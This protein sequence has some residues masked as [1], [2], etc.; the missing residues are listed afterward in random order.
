[1]VPPDTEAVTPP[2]LDVT[3]KLVAGLPEGAV[4]L[5]TAEKLPG[6]ALTDVAAPGGP[7]GPP[8]PEPPPPP[9]QPDSEI[10]AP[11]KTAKNPI[12]T[13]CSLRL[14][15]ALNISTTICSSFNC[16]VV[17]AARGLRYSVPQ[18][19]PSPLVLS[20]SD[21]TIVLG[22]PET[23]YSCRVIRRIDRSSSVYPIEMTDILTEPRVTNGGTRRQ[24]ETRIVNQAHS[25]NANERRSA[26]TSSS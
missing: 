18:V 16:V 20:R 19:D 22:L 5:T 17:S 3:V 10:K 8:L 26:N 15:G 4:Q 6:M 21:P 25:Q 9:P 11:T 13:I 14:L 23:D 12:R 24:H 7:L 2:G 1:M